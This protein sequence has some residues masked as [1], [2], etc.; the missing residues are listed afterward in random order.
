MERESSPR[1]S[2]VKESA[3]D[4]G[5]AGDTGS[6]PAMGRSS[7]GGNGNSSIFA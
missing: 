5:D 1:G 3:A 2:A 7:K 6:I 4:A